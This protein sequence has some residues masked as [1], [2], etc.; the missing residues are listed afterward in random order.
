MSSPTLTTD[1]FARNSIICAIGL[2]LV[3]IMCLVLLSLQRN[4][5]ANLSPMR[6]QSLWLLVFRV[7]AL[8]LCL[9]ALITQILHSAK[10]KFVFYTTWNFTAQIA[11][12]ALSILHAI[13]VRVCASDAVPSVDTMRRFLNVLFDVTFAAAFAIV[14]AFW[15]IVYK[16]TTQL[17][18]TNSVVH[19]ATIG[20]YLIDFM[21]NDYVTQASS[22]PFAML[23]PT[24][25]CAV[26]WLGY[27]TY[28]HGWWPY[29]A[30][31]LANPSAPLVWFGLIFIHAIFSGLT[32]LLSRAK[33]RVVGVAVPQFS[34]FALRPRLSVFEY[35]GHDVELGGTSKEGSNS[36]P[37]R[38]SK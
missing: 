21:C 35:G 19:I 8:T 13:L 12:F 15:T 24:L 29:A 9:A 32:W 6:P 25:Y 37:R 17:D 16:P 18:W 31:D 11:F 3:A 27:A 23:W 38:Q 28:L 10:S 7:A 33:Q 14:V 2:P 36:N 34:S 20:L 26:S 30:V 4:A 5:P 1:V 22:L